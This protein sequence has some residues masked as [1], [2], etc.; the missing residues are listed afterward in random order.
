MTN[1]EKVMK[2]MTAERLAE[3]NVKL[4]TVNSRN[5]FYMTST[6]QLFLPEQYEAAVRYE[7][8]WLMRDDDPVTDPSQ[9]ISVNNTDEVGQ[10]DTEKKAEEN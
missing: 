8:A 2:E 5:L 1:Y 7:Y 9:D 10:E 3:V 4:V 6:G